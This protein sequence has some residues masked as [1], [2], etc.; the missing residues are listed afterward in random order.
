MPHF[1]IPWNWSEQARSNIKHS[2][3]RVAAFRSIME[4]AG[5]CIIRTENTMVCD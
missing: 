3:K 4:K 5:K 2:P 1:V